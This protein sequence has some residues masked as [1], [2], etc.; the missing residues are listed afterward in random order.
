MGSMVYNAIILSSVLQ[1]FAATSQRCLGVCHQESRNVVLMVWVNLETQ[2]QWSNRVSVY[3][4]WMIWMTFLSAGSICCL[5]VWTRKAEIRSKFALL[6]GP[7]ILHRSKLWPLID[8]VAFFFAPNMSNAVNC[9]DAHCV[10]YSIAKGLCS[11]VQL[12]SRQSTT[13]WFPKI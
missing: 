1:H 4:V 11:R 3:S 5:G 7:E 9:D 6:S 13:P 12:F 8:S 2:G 10:K